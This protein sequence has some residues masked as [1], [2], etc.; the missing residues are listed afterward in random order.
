[1]LYSV[2]AKD[3]FPAMAKTVFSTITSHPVAIVHHPAFMHKKGNVVEESYTW[4]FKINFNPGNRG[5][6][7]NLV[8]AGNINFVVIK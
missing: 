5:A 6:G 4:E 2:I 1:V 7:C 8:T 3:R